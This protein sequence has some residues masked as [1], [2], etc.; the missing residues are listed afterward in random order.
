[1]NL[2]AFIKDTHDWSLKTHGP[3]DSTT[4]VVSHIIKELGEIMDDPD[5]IYEWIDVIILA[6]NGASRRGFTPEHIVQALQDKMEINKKRDWP[7]YRLHP[8]DKP[9]E[10]DK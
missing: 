3:G 2:E 4:R 8:K 10:H 5:D 6:L 9:L 1:M 7:N